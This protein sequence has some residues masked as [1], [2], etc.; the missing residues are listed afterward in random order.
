MSER[1]L[2]RIQ[3]LSEVMNRVR[4]PASAAVLCG[5]ELASPGTFAEI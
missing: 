3:V 4:T 2:Q 5:R 1:D